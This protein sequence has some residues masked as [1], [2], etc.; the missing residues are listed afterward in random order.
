MR[1]FFMNEVRKKQKKKQHEI[2]FFSSLLILGL[3][4]SE[5]LHVFK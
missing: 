5:R 2:T 3:D 4:S 1:M